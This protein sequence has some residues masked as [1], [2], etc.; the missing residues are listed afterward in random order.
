MVSRIIDSGLEEPSATPHKMG[1][2]A[3]HTVLAALMEF[4]ENIQ[5]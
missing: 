1:E 2:L 4:I 3:Y 5:A